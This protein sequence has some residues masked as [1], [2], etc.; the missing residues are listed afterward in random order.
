[1][2]GL[3]KISKIFAFSAPFDKFPS[4]LCRTPKSAQ[5]SARA[6]SQNRDM[7]SHIAWYTSLYLWSHSVGRCRL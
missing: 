7:S 6:E 1:V 4:I 5:N 2:K 3:T